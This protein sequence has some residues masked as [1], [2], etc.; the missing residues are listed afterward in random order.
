MRVTARA[1]AMR[2]HR[3]AG[4]CLWVALAGNAAVAQERGPLQD[5]G[6]DGRLF[7]SGTI[8]YFLLSRRSYLS[9]DSGGYDGQVRAVIKHPGGAYEIKL[10][11]Y[12]ARCNAPFDHMVYIAWSDPGQQESTHSVSIKT[13]TR[14]PGEAAKESY[15][16]YW[17]A[18]HNV[19][20]K[21][22]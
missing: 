18:C 7:S 2:I 9:E 13:P 15:N 14:F 3:L 16:L 22:K 12:F 20:Q 8:D 4:I 1:G 5:Y 21:F 17:A 11:D 19:F 10:K 6:T